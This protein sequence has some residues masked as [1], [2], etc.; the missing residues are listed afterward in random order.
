MTRSQFFLLV[1]VLGICLA[2]CND[3]DGV[4]PVAGGPVL[5]GTG[6]NLTDLAGE[7]R[8]TG[9]VT[10][11]A[12]GTSIFPLLDEAILRIAQQDALL[13][14]EVLSPCGTTVATGSGAVDFAGDVILLFEESIVLNPTC[15]IAIEHA[16]AGSAGSPATS[17]AGTR[18]LTLSA[19]GDCGPGLP[20]DIDGG[21][22]AVRCPPGDCSFE[23]CD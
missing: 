13:T 19:E 20:C 12:C 15:T 10:A 6:T 2:G 5:V 22:T 8:L 16:H 23:D 7:W 4:T 11:D 1:L 21:F 17:I 3:D 9:S 18:T 14:V